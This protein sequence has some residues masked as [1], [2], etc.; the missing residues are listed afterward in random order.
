VSITLRAD[1]GFCREAIKAWCEGQGVNFGLGLARNE[2]LQALVNRR[3]E[4]LEERTLDS[5][6]RTR[7]VVAKVEYTAPRAA[8]ARL[9]RLASCT[10]PRDERCPPCTPA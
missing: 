6:S 8:A 5:W 2:H 3:F 10:P 7:R 9:P 4:A 1:S